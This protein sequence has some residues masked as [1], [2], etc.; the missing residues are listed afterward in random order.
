M[1]QRLVLASVFVKKML[2]IL[3]EP[4]TGIDP[5]GVE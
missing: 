5:Q 3:N 2:A 4:I 1:K